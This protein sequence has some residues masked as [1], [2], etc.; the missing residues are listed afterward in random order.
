MTPAR[1]S[2]SLI[3]PGE[4]PMLPSAWDESLIGT[5][6]ASQTGGA[7]SLAE[8]I[9][10]PGWCRDTYVH[11]EVDECFV[12]QEGVVIVR[13]DDH[14]A[15]LTAS[16]GAVLYV[17]RGVARSLHNPGSDVARLLLIHTPG[18]GLGPDSSAGIERVLT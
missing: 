4:G 9:A 8:L 17:P 14:A 18:Q 7:F 16:T 3:A 11:H 10:E 6:G 13:L 1:M 5:V 12:V 15:P 2:S